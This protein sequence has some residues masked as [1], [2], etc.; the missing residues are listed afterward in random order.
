M[1]RAA[2]APDKGDLDPVDVHPL[3]SQDAVLNAFG[4]LGFLFCTADVEMGQLHGVPQEL[5]F[6]QEIEF[7]PPP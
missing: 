3:P 1:D 4:E 2:G 6:Y 7:F 5:G